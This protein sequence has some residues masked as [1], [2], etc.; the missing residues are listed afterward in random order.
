MVASLSVRQLVEEQ[1][2]A[3]ANAPGVER[4]GA[5]GVADWEDER[6]IVCGVRLVGALVAPHCSATV[7]AVLL[8]VL[9]SARIE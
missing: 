8:A 9:L 7:P 4:S 6:S 3:V 5:G 2:Q 1:G